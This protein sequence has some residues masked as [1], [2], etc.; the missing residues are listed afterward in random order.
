[1]SERVM[2]AK[3]RGLLTRR[4]LAERLGVHMQTVT[5]WER[6]GLPTAK[7]GAKGRPSLYDETEVRAWRQAREEAAKSSGIVDVAQERARKER[8]QAILAEQT[9]AIRSREFL[10]KHEIER[11]W[12]AETTAIRTH[13]LAWSTTLAD[14]VYRAATLEGLGGVERVLHDATREVLRELAAG[15]HGVGEGERVPVEAS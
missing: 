14:R 13:L 11:A 4:A 6:D 9:Y 2:T 15:A 7:R 8:A 3:P 12:A 1:M 5:K 10:P